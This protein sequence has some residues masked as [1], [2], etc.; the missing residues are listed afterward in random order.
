M[1]MALLR[2]DFMRLRRILAEV[3]VQPTSMGGWA[4]SVIGSVLSSMSPQI[5][6]RGAQ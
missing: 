1:F 4:Q 3:G 2:Q 6:R 5:G